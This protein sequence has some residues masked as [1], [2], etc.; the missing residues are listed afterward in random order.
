M[1]GAARR[2]AGVR[3]RAVLVG[4]AH[5][6]RR[7]RHHQRQP[8]RH[9]REPGQRSVREP[10]GEPPGRRLLVQPGRV[11]AAGRRPVRR[12]RPRDLPPARR[13]TSGTSRCRR[14][15]TRRSPRGCSSAPT[16]STRSTTRSS[17]PLPSRTPARWRSR[18][19]AAPTRPATSA[20]SP[21]RARRARSSWACGCPGT[22]QRGARL[23]A[24]GRAGHG[25]T[26]ATARAPFLFS[27]Q[28]Y[29]G[30]AARTCR[31]CP[32]RA[33]AGSCAS[34]RAPPGGSS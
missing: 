11:R 27:L 5:L 21:A 26:Y 33:C 32:A 8:P 3:H 17:T 16:S 20:R 18:T 9:P 1:K 12:H 2:L 31:S 25:G 6:A 24:V 19:R 30:E 14:T 10:A 13:A 22:R 15:S 23:V 7:E 34:G 29:V 28:G 4:P